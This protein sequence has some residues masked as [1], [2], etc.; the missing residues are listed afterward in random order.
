[1]RT[2]NWATDA[3]ALEAVRNEVFVLEQRVPKD[4][5]WDGQDAGALHVI[6]ETAGEA[7]A[8]GRLLAS[9]RIGRIA[10]LPAYRRQGIG[11]LVLRALVGEAQRR[12]D[13]QVHLHAQSAAQRFYRQEG[14]EPRGELFEEAGIEHIDMLRVLDFRDWSEEI[15]HASY[16]SP[17]DQLVIALARGARRDLAIL[18][19]VLDAQLFESP[20]LLNAVRRLIRSEQHARVR[21]LVSDAREL[22]RQGRG[23]I[24]LARRAPSKVMFRTLKEHPDWSG[25]TL[26]LRD[27]GGVLGYSGDGRVP[28]FFRPADRASCASA[29]DRFEDLWKAGV[30]SPEFRNLSL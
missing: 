15:K 8:C 27:R 23:L 2:A 17:L 9:G 5:E 16:P 19:P 6:A 14:F 4:I 21:I 12:G 24:N 3:A 22:V 26:V 25:D 28:G 10:V 11:A 7:V 13:R 20:D 18:S 1:M 29:L 30:D